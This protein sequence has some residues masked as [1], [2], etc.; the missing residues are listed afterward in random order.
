M[1]ETNF[2]AVLPLVT[3]SL[4]P[5]VAQLMGL[6]FFQLKEEILDHLNIKDGFGILNYYKDI[7]F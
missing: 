2:F 1:I 7:P 3:L 4:I 6:I 5:E